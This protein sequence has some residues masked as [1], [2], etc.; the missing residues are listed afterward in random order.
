M[1][2]QLGKYC[3]DCGTTE[4]PSVTLN[5][6]P[7]EGVV[8]VICSRC[9][10]IEVET[11]SASNLEKATIAAIA[12]FYGPEHDDQLLPV[13]GIVPTLGG[14]WHHREDGEV[15]KWFSF[16]VDKSNG[17]LVNVGTDEYPTEA[18]ARA[19]WNALVGGKP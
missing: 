7:D 11:F 16:S 15:V 10:R 1:K 17:W 12:A 6:Q 8:H 14:T 9:G 4:T 13:C 3:P 2:K 5:L 18:E 19:A